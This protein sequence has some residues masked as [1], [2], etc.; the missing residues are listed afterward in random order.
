MTRCTSTT[1]TDRGVI[2][3]DANVEDHTD[4]QPGHWGWKPYGAGKGFV[5]IS[6][7][8]NEPRT[9]SN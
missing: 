1:N 8:S 4:E 5:M 2:Q 9:P 6:W 7:G 3:C